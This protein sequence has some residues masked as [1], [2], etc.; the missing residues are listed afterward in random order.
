MF[1]KDESNQRYQGLGDYK[2]VPQAP[3]LWEV[4]PRPP[5]KAAGPQKTPEYSI[6]YS[7]SQLPA[8]G[9]WLYVDPEYPEAYPALFF[10]LGGEFR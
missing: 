1:R 7:D 4:K 6:D 2:N 3:G 10:K 5:P 8:S 9:K